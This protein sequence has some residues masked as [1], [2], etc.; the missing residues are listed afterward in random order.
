MMREEK[1]LSQG[2]IEKKT[3]LLRCYISRV[4]NGHTVPAVETLRNLPAPSKC[5]CIN[6]STMAKSRP[7]CQTF[8]SVSQRMTFCG[9][10][11]ARTNDCC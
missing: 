11:K 7:S 10:V 4:E 5:R 9:A 6:S 1:K 8:P 2:H 3:G